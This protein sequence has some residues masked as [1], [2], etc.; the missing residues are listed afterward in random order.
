MDESYDYG[1]PKHKQKKGRRVYKKGFGR[2]RKNIQI[3]K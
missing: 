1:E 2:R 3:L